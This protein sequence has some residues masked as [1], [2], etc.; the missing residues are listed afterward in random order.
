M[1]P[2]VKKL[3]VLLGALLTVAGAGAAQPPY[4]PVYATDFPDPFVVEHN[5]E[6]LAFSTN[7]RGINLPVASSPNLVDWAPVKDPRRPG[8]HLDAMP[9]LAPWVKEGRTWAPEVIEVGGRWL[10][11][12]TAHYRK[13]DIQCT[14]VAVASDPRG[15][16][17]D[18]SAEPLV[19]QADLGGTIDAHPFRDTDGKLYLY[20]KN[21]GNNPRFRKPT[22]IWAQRLSA[23]GTAL[24]GRPAALLRNDK[25]WE[26]HVIEGEGSAAVGLRHG[27]CH[28]RKYARA[29]HGLVRKSHSLQLQ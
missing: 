12:Y 24:V 2:P 8:R 16:F 10:L 27:L 25:P 21:D 19:C 4:V 23:D 22:D 1:M 5:G 17:R 18:T 26:A 15:P 14:G 6:F 7:S 20:Y 28:L 9:V 29:L 11:Y 3:A 13:K